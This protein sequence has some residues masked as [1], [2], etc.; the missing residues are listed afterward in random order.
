MTTAIVAPDTSSDN[1][2]TPHERGGNA[3]ARRVDPAIAAAQ[4]QAV[5][6]IQARYAMARANPR[7]W[8][9][10]RQRVL[11]TCTRPAFAEKAIYVK[12]M[13]KSSVRGP[14]VRLAEE[15]ARTAGNLQV[16]SEVVYEDHHKRVI[17]VIVVDLETNLVTTGPVTVEKTVERAS[18]KDRLIIAQR[19]NTAGEAVYIVAA[20]D[21]ELTIKTNAMVSKMRRNLV[22]A[23]MP[24]DIV[25]EALDQCRA[26]SRGEAKDQGAARKKIADSFATVGVAVRDVEEYL[27]HGFDMMTPDE[28]Q[29]L[30]EVFA[31]LRDGETRWVDVLSTRLASPATT[32]TPG[33]AKAAA[34]LKDRVKA[35]R[36]PKGAAPSVA[37]STTE[38]V[39]ADQPKDAATAAPHPA[40]AAHAD[41]PM[42]DAEKQAAMVAEREPGDDH[43]EAPIP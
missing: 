7:S 39:P 35:A 22:L 1:G 21:D 18:P 4:A 42:S 10:V 30:R 33:M 25:E 27:G 16:G 31:T 15:L 8:D 14:S 41:V 12:P 29:H 20:T 19:T 38:G 13:G 17:D 26:T 6:T 5:A 11:K 3:L 28:V 43:D 2:L 23:M 37:T 36:G 32:S 24:A 9:D 34:G 40:P